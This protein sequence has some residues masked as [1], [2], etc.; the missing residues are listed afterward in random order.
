MYD[1]N[2]IE[3]LQCWEG[4][5]KVLTSDTDAFSVLHLTM[6]SGGYT[7]APGLCWAGMQFLE[8]V[9]KVVFKLNC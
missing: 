9:S 8:Y 4:L 2:G 6:F 7:G 5:A 3:L 1:R